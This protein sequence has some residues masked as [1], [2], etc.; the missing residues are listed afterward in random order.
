MRKLTNIYTKGTYVDDIGE[1]GQPSEVS[2]PSGGYLLCITETAVKGGIGADEKVDVG[3][4]AVQTSTGDIVYDS[5]QDGFLRSEIE[6]RLL[7]LSPCEFLIVGDLTRTTDKLIQHFSGSNNVFGD[8][9]RLEVV[10]KTKSISSEASTHVTQFYADQLKNSKD[11]KAGALLDKVLQLPMAVTIC[12]SFMIKHLTEYGLQHVFALTKYFQSFSARSHMLINGT[13]LE[14]LEVYRNQTDLSEKGSL[15]WAID[16]TLTRFGQRLLRKW[17]GRPLLDE[18]LLTERVAAV[19]ELLENQSTL[20][21]DQLTKLLTGTKIDLER[22]LIRIYYGKCNR[23]ELLSVL[24]TLQ[25]IA[26]TYTHVGSPSDS[27]FTSGLLGECIAALPLIQ[28]II[29]R[30]LDKINIEAARKD[31]KYRFFRD[32]EETDDIMNRKLSIASVEQ[33]LD[34]HRKFAA[35][36]LGRKEVDYA[37]VSGIEYLIEVPNTDI[38][39]VPA[40]WAKVSGTKKLSRFHTPDVMRL[41]Q[42]RDQHKEALA[43]ACDRAFQSL[44]NEIASHYQSLRDAVSALATLDCLLSLSKVANLPGYNKPNF[45]H[46]TS[47]T[48]IEIADG[49]HPVAEQ[50]LEG[51]YIPFSTTLASPKP[52][53]HLITG[54]NMGGKSSFVRAVALLT[55]LA[56]IGSFV[57]AR[58][59]KLTPTDAI[60]AR[61]GARDNL[62]AGESTFMVEVGETAAMLRSATPR[63][64]VLLDELGRGTSTHDGAA[65]AHA[66]LSHVVKETKCLTLFVTHYQNLARTAD[67]LGGL[68]R[69]VHMKFD[70]ETK[71]NGDEEVTFL[72]EVAEGMAHRSYGL[73]VARLAM[74]PKKVV[75]VARKKSNELEEIMER[76]L[77]DGVADLVKDII[78]DKGEED[79]IERLL[80]CVEQL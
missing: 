60:F 26:T 32:D 72:Y 53:A 55:I 27:E 74:V 29:D 12:L 76:R 71:E 67:G 43:A 57:P 14:S 64:L 80:S 3:I 16:K 77:I 54:P 79:S 78:E 66:V 48:R 30:F 31:D 58:E 59:M 21:V 63:S 46:P 19:E 20:R 22:S 45:L 40:S 6:T 50:I 41:M 52:L 39:K 34:A 51:G 65:I 38:K 36:R 1:L 49:R 10:A 23:P 47:E 11:S 37:T 73:N 68:I 75:D 5:F 15:F 35:E 25:R 24:Q 56:Q 62:F 28:E 42:D 8:K 18:I 9:C 70:A 44:L 69:N 7:H 17:V 13:T 2:R 4:L 33:Q 61:M